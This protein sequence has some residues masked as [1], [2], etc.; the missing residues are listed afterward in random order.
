M[1][2][3]SLNGERYGHRLIVYRGNRLEATALFSCLIQIQFDSINYIDLL[4]IRFVELIVGT[5]AK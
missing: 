2:A 1:L 5:R 3:G 4:G